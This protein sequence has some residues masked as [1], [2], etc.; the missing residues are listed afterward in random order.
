MRAAVA[1]RVALEHRDLPDTLVVHE[2]GLAIAGVRID[3][4]VVNG[5]LTGWEIKTAADSLARLPHQQHAYSQVFDRVWLAADRR[6]V[7]PALA[8]VPAWWGVVRADRTDAG[9]ALRVVRPSRLN[10]DVDLLALV[11]LLWRDEVVEEL[12]ALGAEGALLRAPRD[13]LWQ[14]LAASVP[15]R[16]SRS[17]LQSRVRLRLRCRA[18]WR[19]G[20]PRT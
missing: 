14:A 11:R 15:A 1:R 2:L 7:E 8:M 12:S 13:V 16:L 10:K 6:H 4:A 19:S 17:A 18:G 20:S 5:R 3:L 9:C